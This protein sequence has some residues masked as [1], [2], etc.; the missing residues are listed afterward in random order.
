ML[1]IIYLQHQHTSK[2]LGR[3]RGWYM[4][5]RKMEALWQLMKL[6]GPHFS[7]ALSFRVHIGW[8]QLSYNQLWGRYKPRITWRFGGE[9]Q[10]LPTQETFWNSIC[11]N[12]PSQELQQLREL[13]ANVLEHATANGELQRVLLQAHVH[14][15]VWFWKCSLLMY[16]RHIWN[17]PIRKLSRVQR[18]PLKWRCRRP[19]LCW[20]VLEAVLFRKSMCIIAFGLE[21]FAFNVQYCFHIWNGPIC[22]TGHRWS[23][24]AAGLHCV[25]WFRRR[26]FLLQH[27]V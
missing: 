6:L 14:Y 5:P 9:G 13:G 18:T 12:S 17:G 26:R 3:A 10:H 2:L 1:F 8:L 15:R 24:G 20:L 7:V 21:T 22:F 19:A 16:C 27:H 11:L 23:G 25:D 4:E